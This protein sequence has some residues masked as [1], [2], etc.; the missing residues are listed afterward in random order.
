[1]LSLKFLIKGLLIGVLLSLK[2][3]SQESNGYK[4]QNLS[5]KLYKTKDATITIKEVVENDGWFKPKETF[6]T[7]N[8]N[9][10]FWIK[11]DV[12]DKLTQDLEYCLR[13]NDF[14][15]TSI[16]KNEAYNLVEQ[17][18]GKLSKNN[19]RKSILYYPGVCFNE[20]HVY[21]N[22]YIYLKVRRVINF[23]NPS[24]WGIQLW[25]KIDNDTLQL[26]YT[27]KNIKLLSG[28]YIFS[29]ICLL[30]FLLTI[31]FYL[32]TKRKEF[33]FYAFY[34]LSL[35]L[36]LMPFKLWFYNC[37]F[38][39]FSI[40][41]YAFFQASQVF[42]NIFYM[43]F[44]IYYLS[45][46]K[47][48]KELH[49]IMMGLI[50]TLSIIIVI[51]VISLFIEVF[52][53]HIY[54][55]NFQRLI[56]SIFGVSGMIYLFG[57]GKSRLSYFVAIGSFSYLL[58]ALGFL[59]MGREEYMMLGASIEIIVFSLGL[60]YKI[61]Q[62]YEEHLKVKEEVI[63]NKNKMLRA[64]VNPH[65][66]YNSLNSIQYLIT[67]NDRVPAIKYLSKFGRLVRNILE[68]SI[69][70]NVVLVD[71][72]KM[73]NDYLE[74]E[75]LRFD[76]TFSYE[77]TVG[78]TID[79]NAVEIPFMLL[80]PLVENAII[81]G[82]LPKKGTLKKVSIVF[83]KSDNIINCAIED[84][85]VGRSLDIEN[86]IPGKTSRG[87]LISQQRLASIGG[88]KSSSI[89]IIDLKDKDK[90]PLGTRVLIKIML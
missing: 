67:N 28:Y 16:F 57:A 51:D 31:F 58:G 50:S 8:P 89:E 2:T 77:I 56:M 84:N 33:L 29:G 21:Q 81:H 1:M 25:S 66:I 53:I 44:V 64:Q 72:I 63:I 48:Y 47:N 76:N 7:S 90:K 87:L 5:F 41:I 70:T 14:F 37:F 74:L 61:Y 17:A 15:Y 69:E 62:E 78:N 38:G 80:Q 79:V 6:K 9:D 49:F 10:F 65:F 36:Y 20:T 30:I 54:I 34:V 11:I 60:T 43:C 85:G 19:P 13:L 73:L 3:Y 75:S 68:S 32:Y 4:V 45:T 82:L 39:G 59:F 88:S 55:L 52:V 40:G 35:F 22:Q 46:K 26:K 71:E 18:V 23:D 86:K 12:K 42:I 24:D 83:S 27:E